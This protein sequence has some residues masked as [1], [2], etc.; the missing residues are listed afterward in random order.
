MLQETQLVAYPSNRWRK[1]S[2]VGQVEAERFTQPRIAQLQCLFVHDSLTPMPRILDNDKRA[3]IAQKI[4]NLE[5]VLE[6]CI[7]FAI[8]DDERVR[9][10]FCQEELMGRM[11]Y[12]L[13]AK[14]PYICSEVSPENSTRTD[15]HI[16]RKVPGENIDAMCG[17]L[18]DAE[19]VVRID[20]LL[21]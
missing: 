17:F 9:G 6:V 15:V 20:K 14:I 3:T 19:F 16:R 12:F 11:V 21:R 1:P 10:A 5:P 13:A 4:N 7:L 2:I 18:V 8:V